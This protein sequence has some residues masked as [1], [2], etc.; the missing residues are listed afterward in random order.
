MYCV[1]EDTVEG[2]PTRE[3]AFKGMSEM[4]LNLKKC[5]KVDKL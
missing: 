3:M 4:R 1:Y 5:T 2:L